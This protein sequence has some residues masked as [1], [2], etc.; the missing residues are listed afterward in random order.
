MDK[1]GSE[2]VKLSKVWSAFHAYLWEANTYYDGGH[3]RNLPPNEID[4][5]I[6][7]YWEIFSAYLKELNASL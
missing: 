7:Y 4:A 3:W 1:N 6:D 5:L 2:M